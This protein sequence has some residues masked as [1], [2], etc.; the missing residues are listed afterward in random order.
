MALSLLYSLALT[1]IHDHWKNHSSGVTHVNRGRSRRGE[2]AP[3]SSE[4]QFRNRGGIHPASTGSLTVACV[5]VGAPEPG[6]SPWDP[7]GTATYRVPS[8]GV[9]VGRAACLA[10][11]SGPASLRVRT[12]AAEAGAQFDWAAFLETM[13]ATSGCSF[14][15][16]LWLRRKP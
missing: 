4:G 6:L 8:R 7:G 1:S 2:L 13:R 3:L 14:C 10:G 16:C 12:R 5:T 15:L 9:G 11:P